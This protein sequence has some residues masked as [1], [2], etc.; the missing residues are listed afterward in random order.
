MV[1]YVERNQ[2][3]SVVEDQLRKVAKASSLAVDLMLM[4][5][6]PVAEGAQKHGEHY[7]DIIRYHRVRYPRPVVPSDLGAKLVHLLANH[8]NRHVFIHGWAKH[9]PILIDEKQGSS[10]IQLLNDR[11][12]LDKTGGGLTTDA[13]IYPH[14]Q[15]FVDCS[16]QSMGS[17][18]IDVN[19]WQDNWNWRTRKAIPYVRLFHELTHAERIIK[20]QNN[21][22]P[23]VVPL[24]NQFRKQR[25]LNFTRVVPDK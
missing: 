22:E 7:K 23:M 13:N 19:E 10:T 15:V 5:F 24:V 17:Y 25:G 3:T 12:S 11:T 16:E 2:F 8:Q 6:Q 4:P 1:L 18:K 20:G 9:W 21:S 14:I